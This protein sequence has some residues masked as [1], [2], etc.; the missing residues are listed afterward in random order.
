MRRVADRGK[1][2]VTTMKDDREYGG[3]TS[4]LEV[5][6]LSKQY[7]GF[8]LDKVSFTLPKGY[9]MGYVGPNGAGKSTTLGLITRTRRAANGEVLLDGMRYEDD[10]V[11]YKEKIGYVS[12]MSYFPPG[13]KVGDAALLLKQFYPTFS[14]EKFYHLIR[15]W[16]LPEKKKFSTFSTGMMVKLMFAAVLS[17][18]TRLLILDEA[19]NGLDVL[20]REEILNLLQH[21]IEDGEHSVLFATHIIDDLEQIADYIVMVEGGRV[22]LQDTKEAL[23]ENYILVKGDETLLAVEG[24]AGCLMGVRRSA[25]G[26]SALI[27]SDNAALLPGGTV[28]EKPTISQI[29]SYLMKAHDKMEME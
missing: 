22:L 21:Y 4:V 5:R 6:N 3:E 23:T 9:I 18:E 26:F 25:Y 12:S 24:I 15:G 1:D 8:T 7:R 28:L 27:H 13:M 29:M 14:K 10:P 20:F 11:L 2:M 19:T 17:R 16:N